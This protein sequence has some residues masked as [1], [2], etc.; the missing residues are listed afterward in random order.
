MKKILIKIALLFGINSVIVAQSSLYPEM[1]FVEGGTFIMGDS[2]GDGNSDEHPEHQVT[3]GNFKI[4]KTEVTV[5]QYRQYCGETG[6]KMPESPPWGWLDDHPI[7][8]VSWHDCVAYCDWLSEKLDAEYRLPT[9]AEWEYAARGG[10]QSKGTKYS[11][12][13]S[14]ELV[15]WF[16][17]NSNDRTQQ[18]ATKKPN[19]LGLY[20]MSG[21]VWE[22]CR[23]WYEESYYK[24]S[25]STNPR[26]PSTG[27]HRVL[28]GGSWNASAEDCRV[29][30][31]SNL[32]PGYR[33]YSD[34]FRVVLSQ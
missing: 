26:G 31:R 2:W 17:E 10:K 29:A 7:T 15:G 16:D 18:V 5:R 6:R 1:V 11:G 9:E 28:R 33:S 23:D 27:S 19:E 24:N 12:G 8:K 4:S 34:G 25:P 22:W 20:D 30:N 13:R 3:L 21:N 14:I 32:T